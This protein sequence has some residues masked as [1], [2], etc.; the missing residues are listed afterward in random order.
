MANCP[1]HYLHVC[2]GDYLTTAPGQTPPGMLFFDSTKSRR[3]Y[4]GDIDYLKDIYSSV[5]IPKFSVEKESLYKM[6]ERERRERKEK[7]YTFTPE[8]VLNL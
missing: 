7:L 3:I 2:Q 1:G 4:M 8:Y 5:K 6:R